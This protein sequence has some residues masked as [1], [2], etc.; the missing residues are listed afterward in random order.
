MLKHK[1][2]EQIKKLSDV[3]L[4]RR[5]KKFSCDD[6]YLELKK[7]NENSFFRVCSSYCRKNNH[8][9]YESLIQDVDWVMMKAIK[10]FNPKKKSKFNSWFTNHSRY[11]IL[12]TIKNSIENSIFIPQDNTNLDLLNSSLRNH[13]ND[14]NEFLKEHIFS[15]LL[16]NSKDKRAIEIF[17]MRFFSEKK[18]QRWD[19]IA[20]NMKLSTQAV[21]TIFN[22]SKKILKKELEN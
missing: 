2:I 12:N 15:V 22:N 14:K 18:E 10:S 9:E 17:K 7:R 21:M 11:H 8:L 4:V 5:I 20:K 3:S 13:H 19:T 6:S 1:T 16:K